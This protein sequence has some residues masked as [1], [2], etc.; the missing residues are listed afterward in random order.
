[1]HL[2]ELVK[3]AHNN[4]VQHGFWEP[5]P[6]IGTYIALIHSELSEALEEE[7]AGNPLIWHRGDK[8]EGLAVELA[9]T[10]IRIADLC[11]Y[12]GVDLDAVVAEKMAYNAGRPH[13]LW[14]LLSWPLIVR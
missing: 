5:S 3:E 8:P 1:M 11:G 10:V 9:D 7:R 12:L 2:N 14:P 4:A 6:E 13:K